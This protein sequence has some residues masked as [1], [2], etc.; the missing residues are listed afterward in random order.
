MPS[1]E[2]GKTQVTVV[3]GHGGDREGIK[4]WVL[5]MEGMECQPDSFSWGYLMDNW[6]YL[7]WDSVKRPRLE[8]KICKSSAYLL[9]TRGDHV[10]R[11]KA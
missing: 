3:V 11:K 2:T 10:D 4:T 7:I 5:A 9:G 6:I 8:T 1:S